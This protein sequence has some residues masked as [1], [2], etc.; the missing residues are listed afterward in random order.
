MS[1]DLE[2]ALRRL[3]PEPERP[4]P[5]GAIIRRARRRRWAL[6]GSGL[7]L[8]VGAVVAARPVV[9]ALGDAPTEIAR[10]PEPSI[11]RVDT[12]R[13]DDLPGWLAYG[14]GAIWVSTAERTIQRIDPA[15]G[16]VTATLA[17]GRDGRHRDPTFFG[18]VTTGGGAVWATTSA[19][20][21]CRLIE[22][23]PE[24]VEVVASV[25]AP[26][27]YPLLVT[28]SSIWMGESGWADS[29][30][31][32]LERDSFDRVGEVDLG[33][34]CLSGI[35]AAAG[36]VWVGRQVVSRASEGDLVM[37]LDLVRID[38]RAARLE[39]EIP[40]GHGP[41]EPGDTLLG[42]TMSS[43]GGLV[44]V[45]RPEEGVVQSIH[46]G[47]GTRRAT[48]EVEWAAMPDNPVAT[49]RWVAIPDLNRRVVELVDPRSGRVVTVFDTG[50]DMG[51]NAAS[52]GRYL[53]IIHP[54][55]DQV[56]KLSVDYP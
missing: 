5:V 31:V 37:E 54:H 52:D 1:V 34:C 26:G 40:L 7:L 8:V 11:R 49:A 14:H 41:Y 32:A 46:A 29:R 22:I 44:W 27:C 45:A 16:E 42:N 55:R 4:V 43:H 56:V 33:P 18:T 36:D 15:T 2:E 13:V 21:S 53:W 30:V 51:G 12:T 10:R 35:A 47:T 6:R 50:A 3:A 39:E 17:I 25:K 23:D 19:G 20:A 9:G 48:V 28:P 38:G 24:T